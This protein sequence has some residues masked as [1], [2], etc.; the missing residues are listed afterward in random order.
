MGLKR[1]IHRLKCRLDPARPLSLAAELAAHDRWTAEDV[2]QRNLALQREAVASAFTHIPFYRRKYAE[3]GFRLADLEDPSFLSK[4]PLLTRAEIREHES[5]IVHPA[6]HDVRLP[7]ATTGGSTGTPLRTFNDPRIP[8]QVLSW[9]M[10][11]WWGVDVSDSSGYLY[12]SVPLGW[13][14]LRQR[15][16]LW[17]TRREWLSASA[18]TPPNMARFHSA[19][20]RSKP[21]YLVGYVGAIEVFAGYLRDEGLSLPGLKAVWT[22]S[23]PLPEGKRQWLQRV[24]QCPVYTQYGSCEFYWISAECRLQRGLHIGTDARHVEIVDENGPVAAGE[25][26]EIVVTDLLN[27][28]FPLIRYQVGDRGRLLP[29]PC[30]C[31]LPFPLMDYVRGRTSDL[32]VTK[33]GTRIPGEFWTT[34]CDDFTDNVQAFQVYQR[35]DRQVEVRMQMQAGQ[36]MRP[37]AAVIEERLQ[38]QY[39]SDLDVRCIE[40]H[41]DVNDNGKTRFVVSDVEE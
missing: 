28:A 37:V 27:R 3:A 39:G 19:L 6:F 1:A 8:L 31:G 40:T 4:L 33:A 38:R 35:A 41:V 16:L 12:R 36:P 17:P 2:K 20:A 5:E 14:R 24:F 13:K 29:T 26:G 18:M 21:A 15:L 30:A 10:L 23:A 7:S 32:I 25:Y 11:E 9:R 34:I 22:T